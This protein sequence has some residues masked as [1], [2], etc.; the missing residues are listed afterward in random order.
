MVQESTGQHCGP[1]AWTTD[2]QFAFLMAKVA[3]WLQGTE[4]DHGPFYTNMT[5][6]FLKHFGWSLEDTENADPIDSELDA[7]RNELAKQMSEG[8]D[9]EQKSLQGKFQSLR[10]V[11]NF[12]GPFYTAEKY[13][14]SVSLTGIDITVK[15]WWRSHLRCRTR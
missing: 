13:L 5:W 3:I 15:R 7:I 6:M 2:T 4:A 10:L 12:E 9:E 1:P 14:F 8:T 11:S